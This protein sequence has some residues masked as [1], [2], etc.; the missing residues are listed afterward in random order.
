VGC[1]HRNCFHGDII[2][3]SAAIFRQVSLRKVLFSSMWSFSRRK[4]VWNVVLHIC[5]L[6]LT[7]SL[8]TSS[9]GWYCLL[10]GWG[11]EPLQWDPALQPGWPLHLR[12]RTVL[13]AVTTVSFPDLVL[14]PL[15]WE[16]LTCHG[17]NFSSDPY[18]G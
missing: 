5:V 14:L 7:P 9:R 17:R 6:T 10:L 15:V 8:Q 12:L 18:C 1:C 11:T 4:T 16:F 2:N 3:R 13:V